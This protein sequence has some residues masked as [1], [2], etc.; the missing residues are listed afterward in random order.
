MLSTALWMGPKIVLYRE[1]DVQQWRERG[2]VPAHVEPEVPQ[3][4]PR[5]D[6]EMRP[7]HAPDTS[8]ATVTPIGPES[9]LDEA[10][11]RAGE[12]LAEG[13]PALTAAQMDLIVAGLRSSGA[14]KTLPQAA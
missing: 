3:V 1:R 5:I 9:P 7:L 12:V 14:S 11:M 8:L 4:A 13:A 2:L 6:R 10:L